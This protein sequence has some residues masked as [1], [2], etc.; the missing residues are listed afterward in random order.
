M[1]SNNSKRLSD[2]V[3]SHFTYSSIDLPNKFHYELHILSD[4]KNIA[5]AE[6]SLTDDLSI[7]ML[8]VRKDYQASYIVCNT[9]Y[10]K[11]KVTTR[12]M[13]MDQNYFVVGSNCYKSC[14][15]LK[16]HF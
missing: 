3:V 14:I 5:H 2:E 8:N 4:K 11:R 1:F 7:I 16:S 15:A 9:F 12:Y 6:V 13:I 10:I